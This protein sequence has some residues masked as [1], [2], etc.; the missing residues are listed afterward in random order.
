VCVVV[1]TCVCCDSVMTD[2]KKVGDSVM[3]MMMVV[4]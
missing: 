1:V 2:D 4:G 3:T